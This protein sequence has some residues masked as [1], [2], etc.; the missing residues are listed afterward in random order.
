[1]SRRNASTSR[2]HRGTCVRSTGPSAVDPTIRYPN[3]SRS[4]ATLCTRNGERPRSVATR[5]TGVVVGMMRPSARASSDSRGGATPRG[6]PPL[7]WAS[8]RRSESSSQIGAPSRSARCSTIVRAS[9]PAQH[10]VDQ[11]LLQAQRARE[12]LTLRPQLGGEVAELAAPPRLRLPDA[13]HVERGGDLCTQRLDKGEIVG[14]EP[15][16]PPASRKPSDSV[17]TRS[18]SANKACTPASAQRPRHLVGVATGR[19]ERVQLGAEPPQ[20]RGDAGVDSPSARAAAGHRHRA[21]GSLRVP[22]TA[23]NGSLVT[24]RRGRPRPARPRPPRSAPRAGRTR[25]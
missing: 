1:M 23:A 18:G 22:A 15:R 8:A 17:E 13:G 19:A 11:L 24:A 20:R 6:D 12:Q 2:R 4:V 21:V 5:P 10:Q 16:S 3:V 25:A 7:A 9:F 14:I